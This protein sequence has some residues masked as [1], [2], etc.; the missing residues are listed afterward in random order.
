RDAILVPGITGSCY[1]GSANKAGDLAR[2][3]EA[4]AKNN[5]AGAVLA[6]HDALV[7][8]CGEVIAGLR[9]YAKP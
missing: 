6:N 9:A 4:A 3:L 5:D 1:G 7:S 8:H 2:E